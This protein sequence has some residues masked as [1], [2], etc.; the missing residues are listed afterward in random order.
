MNVFH[1]KKIVSWP[2][3][4]TTL[5]PK[6]QW[7]NILVLQ[8]DHKGVKSIKIYVKTTIVEVVVG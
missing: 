6:N 2:M 1:I 3:S 4:N 8:I 7:P 5:V